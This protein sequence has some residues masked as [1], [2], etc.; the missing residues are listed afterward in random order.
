MD[1]IPE[2][3]FAMSSGRCPLSYDVGPGLCPSDN[4]RR[5]GETTWGDQWVFYVFFPR[6]KTVSSAEKKTSPPEIRDNI[7]LIP[8]Y[9]Y[10]KMTPEWTIQRKLEVTWTSMK[11]VG[12]LIWLAVSTCVTTCLIIYNYI[13]IIYISHCLEPQY[14]EI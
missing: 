1:P 4:T 11:W 10:K 9:L 7:H 6:G 13:Y 14:S 3:N 8:L 2:A 12:S 5:P